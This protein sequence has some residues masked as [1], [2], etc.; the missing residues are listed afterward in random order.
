VPLCRAI[1]MAGVHNPKNWRQMNLDSLDIYR[2]L[3]IYIYILLTIYNNHISYQNLIVMWCRVVWIYDDGPDGK[4]VRYHVRC[5]FLAAA[6]M[7]DTM[8]DVHSLQRQRCTIPCAMYI[9]DVRYHVRCTTMPC[10]MYSTL[11]IAPVNVR[12]HVRHTMCVCVW[13]MFTDHKF[14]FQCTMCPVCATQ[15][16]MVGNYPFFLLDSV[17]FEWYA[18]NCLKLC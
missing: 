13:C 9:K 7:Y 1:T 16:A 18:T 17:A 14:N 8:C 2:P 3:W 15:V 11:R 12:C 4:D 10:A 6:K 5:T